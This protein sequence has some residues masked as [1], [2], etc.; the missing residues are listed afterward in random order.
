MAVQAY[1]ISIAADHVQAQAG[2]SGIFS[3]IIDHLRG[4]A[5]SSAG[6]VSGQEI[7]VALVVPFH[8]GLSNDKHKLRLDDS[9]LYRPKHPGH[10]ASFYIK[11]TAFI[12]GVSQQAHNLFAVKTDIGH[13]ISQR[14]LKKLK[15][16]IL[17]G[18]NGLDHIVKALD[19]Q[20]DSLLPEAGLQCV[21]FGN[22][23]MAHDDLLLFCIN[24][25]PFPA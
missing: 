14:W 19:K 17:I 18:L 21:E 15:Q 2:N 9:A 6:R 22:F 20:A 23:V 13:I 11:G 24:I 16:H 3:H 12:V 8:S 10:P 25:I 4:N 5:L 1:G 7:D